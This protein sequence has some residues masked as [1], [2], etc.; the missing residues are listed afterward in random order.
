MSAEAERIRRQ[1]DLRIAIDD[2][3]YNCIINADIIKTFLA[4]GDDRGRM[5]AVRT[6]AARVRDVVQIEKMLEE[7]MLEDGTNGR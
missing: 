7:S 4:L 1:D 2:A 6:F 3:L 5:Y